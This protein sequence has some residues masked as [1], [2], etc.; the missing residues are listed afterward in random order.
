MILSNYRSF[1]LCRRYNKG[2]LAPASGC[3][4]L[5]FGY[6]GYAALNSPANI[7]QPFWLQRGQERFFCGGLLR[8]PSLGSCSGLGIY[9][10]SSGLPLC[11]MRR[12][13]HRPF[14]T[15]LV[16]ALVPATSWLANIRRRFATVMQK[17]GVFGALQKKFFSRLRK[18]RFF[19]RF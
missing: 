10:P 12:S 7:W 13:F 14:R 18:M 3:W 9:G 19:G 6:R 11:I 8:M 2:F 4:F 16:F 17:K 15:A 1:A 5:I